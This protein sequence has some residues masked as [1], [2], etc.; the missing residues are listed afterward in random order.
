MVGTQRLERKCVL[1][2]LSTWMLKLETQRLTKIYFQNQLSTLHAG[3][4]ASRK[5]VQS[6]TNRA[7]A[8]WEHNKHLRGMRTSESVPRAVIY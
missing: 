7:L 6:A 3:N 4:I 2:P 1:I 5:D 8:S